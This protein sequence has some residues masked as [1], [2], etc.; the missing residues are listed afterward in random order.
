[1]ALTPFQKLYRKLYVQ[2]LR[3][4][5]IVNDGHHDF[6]V[7]WGQVQAVKAK[8]LETAE[9]WWKALQTGESMARSKIS[10]GS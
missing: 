10:K 6:Y 3:E 5:N 8:A 7:L 1:M 4:S 2:F 9:R